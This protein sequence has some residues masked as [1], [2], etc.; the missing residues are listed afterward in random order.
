MFGLFKMHEVGKE[1]RQEEYDK[2]P[3]LTCR[4]CGRKSY[5]VHLV[6]WN[7]RDC[8]PVKICHRC[9]H[10]EHERGMEGIDR[11]YSTC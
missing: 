8:R 11:G 9:I 5:A 10:A 6:F 2:P 7:G 3:E 1:I 4:L